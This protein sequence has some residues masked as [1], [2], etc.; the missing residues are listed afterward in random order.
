[1]TQP[2]SEHTDGKF[3]VSR[4]DGKPMLPDEPVFVFRAHDCLLPAVLNHYRTICEANG[5]SQEHLDAIDV[6]RER[7]LVWQ[8]EHGA[9]VPD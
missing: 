6:H 7:I 3:R 9:K 8:R 1:M 2:T 5:C 4:L